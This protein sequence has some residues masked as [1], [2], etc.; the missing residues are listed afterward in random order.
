MS[1]NYPPIGLD[2]RLRFG[3]YGPQN[4]QPG[5]E[6]WEVLETD[7]SYVT[8]LIENADVELDNEAYEEYLKTE[9]T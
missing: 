5:K 7:P 2:D 4:G 9:G 3:K 8:W 1:S 6:L